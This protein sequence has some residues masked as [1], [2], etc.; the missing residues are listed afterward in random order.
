MLVWK[1]SEVK[2]MI[3]DKIGENNRDNLAQLKKKLDKLE[4]ELDNV[5]FNKVLF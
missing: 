1:L 3:A 2:Q 5:I 4:I